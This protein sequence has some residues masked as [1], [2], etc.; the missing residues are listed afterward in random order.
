MVAPQV[1]AWLHSRRMLWTRIEEEKNEPVSHNL[2]QVGNF[3]PQ[4]QLKVRERVLL[5][6]AG[7]S[8]YPKFSSQVF[9][10]L[11]NSGFR[12]YHPDICPEKGL[13]EISGTRKFRFGFGYSRIT[14]TKKIDRRGRTM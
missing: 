8:G 14:Q 10:V 9:R 5:D 4:K 11:R 13:P 12:N 1:V 2:W 7:H 6:K 3:L